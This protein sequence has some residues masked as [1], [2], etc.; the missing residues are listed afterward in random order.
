MKKTR[1]HKNLS[2]IVLFTY[3]RLEH[4]IRTINAL[5]KNPLAVNSKLFIYSDGPA[6]DDDNVKIQ[7]VRRYIRQLKGFDFVEI[8]EQQNNTGLAN[9]IV[10]GVTEIINVYG[11][12]II[13]EDDIVTSPQFLSYM[14]KALSYYKEQKDVWHISGWNYPIDTEN[15]GD[16]F[17]WRT[18]NCWGWATWKDRWKY[19]KKNPSELIKKMSKSEIEKFNLDNSANFWTQVQQNYQGQMNTWAIFW[20]ATIF[21]N[22]GLC[23]NPSQTYVENIGFDGSG[24]NTGIRYNYSNTLNTQTKCNFPNLYE[25]NDIAVNKIKL[26][27]RGNESKNIFFSQSL[28]KIYNV[29]N[30]L[31]KS[32]DKFILYGA[33]SGAEL[34]MNYLNDSILFIIDKS[35]EQYNF[36]KNNIPVYGIEKLNNI[37]VT[38]KIIISPIGRFELIKNELT[39]HY[40]I[41]ESQLISLD[42]L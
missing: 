23:F 3:N 28:Y 31:N 32:N 10:T 22:N 8:I 13:I 42:I 15:L 37:K 26:F 12:T 14:N 29:L 20:Y 1:N 4:T 40:P 11:K 39:N 25:E 30:R 7:A 35:P 5:K 21:N 41:H 19:Y 27:L 38:D 33:G 18:M 9:S 36:I 2:P 6:S 24:T 34:V 16:G 17:F